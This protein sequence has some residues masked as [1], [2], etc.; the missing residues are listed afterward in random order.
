MVEKGDNFKKL[1]VLNMRT[2]LMINRIKGKG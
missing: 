2:N 1:N